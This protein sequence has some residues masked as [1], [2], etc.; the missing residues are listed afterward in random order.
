MVAGGYWDRFAEA[1]AILGSPLRPSAE[2]LAFM[3][4]TVRDRTAAA[5]AAPL[6]ALLL[7]S[8]P[9]L[10][11]MDWPSNTHLA[12]ID[13]SFPMARGVWPGNIPGRRDIVCADWLAAPFRDASFHVAAGD[14][15]VNCLS[16]PGG[17]Y[18]LSEELARLLCPHGLLML[19]TYLQVEPRESPDELLGQ[20]LR[21][22]LPGFDEFKLRLMMA[23]QRDPADGL[24][25]ENVYQW[26]SRRIDPVELARRTG[27]ALAA[28][29][30]M[31]LYKDSATVYA[32]P[33]REQ[34]LSVLLPHFEV[35]SSMEPSHPMGQR[36]LV[37]SLRGRAGERAL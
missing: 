31:Q 11:A 20:A 5:G 2:E 37:L 26:V 32:F 3:G 1:Y 12:A 13:R 24:A 8:T 14:G 17:I 6:R 4:R 28:I 34:L 7:G 19:R 27:W 9:G 30:T 10:A 23:L 35:F 21:G 33:T 36:C 15:S 18:A 16:Y 29:E 22:A 25:V